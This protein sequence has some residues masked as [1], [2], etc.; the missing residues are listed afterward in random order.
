MPDSISNLT[1][2]TSV[3]QSKIPACPGSWYE[4]LQISR[5]RDTKG[6]LWQP[7]FGHNME[8]VMTTIE[9]MQEY[10]GDEN[11]FVILAHDPSLRASDAPFFPEAIN[12]WKQRG[13][14]QKL[15]WV[16]TEEI[17]DAIKA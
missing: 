15:R 9:S 16:W 5:S 6:P 4:D 11:V 10:D 14:S 7:A 8:E 12:D 1:A 13:L 17:I 2:T 3:Q